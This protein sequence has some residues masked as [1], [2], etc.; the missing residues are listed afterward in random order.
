M[1]VSGNV[2]EIYNEMKKLVDADSAYL[3][4]SIYDEGDE[5]Y[6]KPFEGKPV[7]VGSE[8]FVEVLDGNGVLKEGEEVMIDPNEFCFMKVT[9]V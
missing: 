6:F 1:V 9:K 4:E 3:F 5:D 2:Q 7:Y 8:M